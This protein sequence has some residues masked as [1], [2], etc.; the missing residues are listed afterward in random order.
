[1][2]D[3][4]NLNAHG[5]KSVA[6]ADLM[7]MLLDYG[8]VLPWLKGLLEEIQYLRDGASAAEDEERVDYLESVLD[9]LGAEYEETTP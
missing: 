4:T 1:M 9:G 6:D 7:P 2:A 8:K 5:L 3:Y